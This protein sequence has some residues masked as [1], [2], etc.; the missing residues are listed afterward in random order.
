MTKVGMSL[1][2]GGAKGSYQLGVIKALDEFNMLRLVKVVSGTS[3]GAINALLFM[4]GKSHEE[5]ISVWR[6]L[7]NEEIYQS[8]SQIRKSSYQKMF[9]LIPLFKKLSEQ[10]TNKEISSSKIECYVTASEIVDD[11]RLSQF[12]FWDMKKVYFHLNTFIQPRKAVLASV[13]IP[14]LFG[15]TKILGKYYVDGGVLNQHPLEP[16]IENDCNVIFN[17]PVDQFFKSQKYYKENITLIDFT[18]N[19][20]FHSTFVMDLIDAVRFEHKRIEERYRY[21]YLVGRKV[22]EK[23]YNTQILKTDLTFNKVNKFTMIKLTPDEDR[24]IYEQIREEFY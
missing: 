23:L 12:K 3:I 5:M 6:D 9:D 19:Y 4:A 10:V 14:G 21:G 17:I 24:L 2:G 7:N 16:L 8:G 20:A 11:K 18:S 15:K 22:L 13:S 1:G